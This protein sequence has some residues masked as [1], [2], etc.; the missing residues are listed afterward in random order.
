MRYIKILTALS[1]VCAFQTSAVAGDWFGLYAGASQITKNLTGDWTTTETRD[2][3]GFEIDSTSDTTASL[4]SEESDTGLLVG[5][6]VSLGSFVLGVEA[7]QESIEHNDSIDDRIP[8][9]GDTSSDPTS[10]VR[11]HAE[12]DDTNLRLRAGYLII[13]NLLLYAVT[14]KAE[15][16]VTVTSTCPA[17]TNV[18]NPADG[19]QSFSRKKS[20]SDN[21][22]GAGVE[23]Q[24]LG[25][26]VRAERL[27]VDYGDFSFNAFPDQIGSSF[28]ADA[29]VGLEAEFTQLSA[30]Y[31]F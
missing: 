7:V 11:F 15:L 13:P 14:G 1:L 18:C 30:S 21:A 27:E 24:L 2:P 16:D 29:T 17:D 26:A 19:T 12:S 10:Y 4:E 23:F 3:I 25:F 31:Q 22:T 6:N 8:G 5:F 28:G 20:L 9:L